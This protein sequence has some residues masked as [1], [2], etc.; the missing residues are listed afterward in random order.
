MKETLDLTPEGRL[1]A[2]PSSPNCVSSDAPRSDG[3]H[4]IAPLA[5]DGDPQTAWQQLV[6]LLQGDRSIT[7]VVQRD[8]FIHAEARTR[9]MRFVDDVIFH[10][11]PD[12]G[13]IAM[14][15]ASRVGYSDLGKN[16]KRLEA[17]RAAMMP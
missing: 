2:C 10:L 17:V 1:P 4:Y 3:K 15:S 5:I 6:G 8:D 13:V 9:I 14:R 11:R 7:I 16:R 12:E